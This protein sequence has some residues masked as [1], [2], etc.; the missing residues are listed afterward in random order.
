MA[1]AIRRLG[2]KL[3]LRLLALV[4]RPPTTGWRRSER[5]SSLHGA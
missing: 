1:Q 2:L 3:A 5:L 4:S